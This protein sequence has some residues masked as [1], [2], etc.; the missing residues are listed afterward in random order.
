MK[1]H[2]TMTIRTGK[3]MVTQNLLKPM[4]EKHKEYYM[5]RDE[6]ISL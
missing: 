2:P 5:R 6:N 1:T 3:Q 4:L